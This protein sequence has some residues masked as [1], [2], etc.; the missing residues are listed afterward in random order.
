MS[1][2]QSVGTYE[3]FTTPTTFFVDPEGVITDMRLGVVSRGWIDQNMAA[4]VSQAI[5]E[6]FGLVTM[7]ERPA[8]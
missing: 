4:I 3:I 2:G 5:E 1:M 8:A 6:L 7:I